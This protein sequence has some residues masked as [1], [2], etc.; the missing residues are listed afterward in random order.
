MSAT[1]HA[2]NSARLPRARTAALRK[3][4]AFSVYLESHARRVYGAADMVELAAA[5]GEAQLS[6]ERIAPGYRQQLFAGERPADLVLSINSLRT[7]SGQSS[8]AWPVCAV[9]SCS[10]RNSESRLVAKVF[11]SS[12]A[13]RAVLVRRVMIDPRGSAIILPLP[14]RWCR[15]CRKCRKLPH[16]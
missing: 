3:A 8:T 16:Q 11:L 4:I 5:V 6:A 12:F 2:R 1:S 10:L 9:N 13:A 7:T 15:K 14:I